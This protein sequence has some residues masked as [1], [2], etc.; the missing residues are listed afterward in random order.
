MVSK[1]LG[2]A[3]SKRPRASTGE[4]VLPPPTSLSPLSA[5]YDFDREVQLVQHVEQASR[6]LY[7][8]MKKSSESGF[9]PNRQLSRIAQDLNS[10]SYRSRSLKGLCVDFNNHATQLQEMGKELRAAEEAMFVEPIKKFHR[11]FPNVNAAI[12]KRERKL[13]EYEKT[14]AKLDRLA[15]S[16]PRFD[17]TSRAVQIARMEFEQYEQKIARDMPWLYEERLEY[18]EP[19]VDAVIQSQLAHFSESARLTQNLVGHLDNQS[20]QLPDTEYRAM[21]DKHLANFRTLSIVSPSGNT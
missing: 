7:K 3:F 17:A 15:E 16:N 6:K 20:L 21:M 9:Q 2:R 8:D 5:T 11:V 19:C 1:R 12:K 13:E 4:S 18:L 10:T 14:Q